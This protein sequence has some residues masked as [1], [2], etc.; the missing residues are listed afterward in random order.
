MVFHGR[1]IQEVLDPA[2]AQRSK[3][4]VK[5]AFFSTVNLLRPLRLQASIPVRT[6]LLCAPEFLGETCGSLRVLEVLLDNRSPGV[7]GP[8]GNTCER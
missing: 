3:D 8:V 5:W 2:C 6:P 4:H 1:R 7:Q